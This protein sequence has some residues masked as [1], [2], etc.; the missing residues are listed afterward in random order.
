MTGP[1]ITADTVHY[2]ERL[3]DDFSRCAIPQTTFRG[4]KAVRMRKRTMIC[5]ASEDT[6][7]VF[8]LSQ[9]PDASPGRGIN[10]D[11]TRKVRG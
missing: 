9:W 4:L 7:R 8:P 5:V 10:A 11:G 2:W 1:I 6:W 3:M